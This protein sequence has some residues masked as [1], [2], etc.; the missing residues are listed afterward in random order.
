MK[1]PSQINAVDV[2]VAEATGL[3]VGETILLRLIDTLNS[4]ERVA[5]R[6]T[7]EAH[8]MKELP[9]N[10]FYNYETQEWI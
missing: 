2:R 8:G 10:L 7:L 3:S 6:E 5:L 9:R 1:T 4:A